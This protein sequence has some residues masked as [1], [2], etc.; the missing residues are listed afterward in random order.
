M[1]K[2]RIWNGVCHKVE[3]MLAFKGQ[4]AYF[5]WGSGERVIPSSI[6][7]NSLMREWW[8]YSGRMSG[9]A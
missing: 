7:N 6:G 1:C 3:F 8:L 5:R 9:Q 2:G 4:E